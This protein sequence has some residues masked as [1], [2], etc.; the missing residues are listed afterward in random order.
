V[1]AYLSETGVDWLDWEDRRTKR[2][3]QG[4]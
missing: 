4:R 2:P 3:A 1:S